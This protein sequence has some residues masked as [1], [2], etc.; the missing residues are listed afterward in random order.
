MAEKGK[1]YNK[2]KLRFELIDDLALEALAEVYTKGAHKYTIYKDKSNN[3]IRGADI[4]MEE[5]GKYEVVDDGANNWRKGMSWMDTYGCAMRHM[6]AWK[7]RQD[8]DP[9]LGTLHLG[10]A[11]WNMATLINFSKTHPELDDRPFQHVPKIGLDIDEVL[12]NWVGGWRDYYKIENVPT[13]WYFDREIRDRFELMKEA[14]T[15]DA[16]Y[17][18]LKPLIKPEDIP[19]EP[20]CYITSRPCHVD[21]TTAWLDQ[22]GFPTKPVYCVGVG[23]SKVEVAK[24]AGIDIFV[25][26]CYDNYVALNEAGITCYL[27]DAPHNHRYTE[28][29]R[30]KSLKELI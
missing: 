16:F 18:S 13:S 19:F 6:Q 25:D 3:E 14:G 22:N 7:K 30:I 29:K 20:H 1:R 27:M 4:P 17:M 21:I 8:I 2:G 23:Q 15:L 24:K 9:E 12:C 11:M 26:D 10:N 28:A 5:V